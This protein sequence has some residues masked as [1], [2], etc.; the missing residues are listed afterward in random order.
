MHNNTIPISD[1]KYYKI[2]IFQKNY[3][4]NKNLII[5]YL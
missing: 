1:L 5:K 2:K 4:F 3:N